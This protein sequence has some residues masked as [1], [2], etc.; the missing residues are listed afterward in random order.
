MLSYDNTPRT[1]LCARLL[2]SDLDMLSHFLA[3]NPLFTWTNSS[4]FVKSCAHHVFITCILCSMHFT[5]ILRL[6]A[7][8]NQTG[9]IKVIGVMLY[10]LLRNPYVSFSTVNCVTVT[11][12]RGNTSQYSLK[13]I[14]VVFFW[15]LLL[16]SY[17]SNHSRNAHRWCVVIR[18]AGSAWLEGTS[19]WTL[20]TLMLF[21]FI[22]KSMYF[23]VGL[24]VG[25][26]MLF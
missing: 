16:Y 22:L 11:S 15:L 20:D 24:Y 12:S 7:G 5:T 21:C 19:A 6:I 2:Y 14:V 26:G 4:K 13:S 18:K 17:P 1:P 3:S 8:H 9:I 10:M 25:C 23:L